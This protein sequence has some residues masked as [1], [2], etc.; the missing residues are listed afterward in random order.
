MLEKL[1]GKHCI[2]WTVLCLM[3][4]V[5]AYLGHMLDLKGYIE[6]KVIELIAVLVFGIV[7]G[8]IT[9][10]LVNFFISY[11]KQCRDR[12]SVV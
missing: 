8:M 12:K 6:V 11:S 7:S 9:A 3:Y 1:R 2:I 4:S 10:L 5:M